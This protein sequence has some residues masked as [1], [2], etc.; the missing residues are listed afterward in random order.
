MASLSPGPLRR[1]RWKELGLLIIP[2]IILLLEMIQLPIAQLYRLKLQT[3]QLSIPFTPA[4]LPT[5]RDLIPVL[6]LIAALAAMNMLL[7]FFFPKADQVL[8]PLVGLLSGIGVLM[9]LR[10]GP[11]P[12]VGDSMLGTRQ[13]AG[14]SQPVPALRARRWPPTSTTTA[15]SSWSRPTGSGSSSP[16]HCPY[17]RP[18]QRRTL[19]ACSVATRDAHLRCRRREWS[20]PPLLSP[21]P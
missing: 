3:N 5:I 10:L 7:S 19:G 9:A 20:P 16:T 6:G 12:R 4:I 13:L 1:Y 11:E 18:P 14:R 21:V 15:T 8:L 2:F 17:R